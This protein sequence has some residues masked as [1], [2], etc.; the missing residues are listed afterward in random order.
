MKSSNRDCGRQSE[1]HQQNNCPIAPRHEVGDL[2]VVFD[3]GRVAVSVR[4]R[5]G[6]AGGRRLTRSMRAGCGKHLIREHAPAAS[7]AAWEIYHDSVGQAFRLT[8]SGFVRREGLTYSFN[9][10]APTD[11]FR[12]GRII[13]FG[14]RML[15]PDGR[16]LGDGL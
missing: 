13:Q 12:T 2:G 8:V 7:I 11:T 3:A 15:A 1:Q 4:M 9:T 16:G 5:R 14:I 10:I 6:L